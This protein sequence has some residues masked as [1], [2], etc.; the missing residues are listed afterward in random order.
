ME[1]WNSAFEIYAYSSSVPETVGTP[2]EVLRCGIVTQQKETTPPPRCRECGYTSLEWL[3]H[4]A[5]RLTKT[6]YRAFAEQQ[7]QDCLRLIRQ[8][9]G[10]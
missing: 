7:R 10:K 6:I 9:L 3:R 4:W 2:E 5:G 8:K 1:V